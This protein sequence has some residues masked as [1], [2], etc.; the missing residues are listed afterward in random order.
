[1][2]PEALPG[3]QSEIF[4]MDTNP[5]CFAQDDFV[6][7]LSKGLKRGNIVFLLGGVFSGNPSPVSRLASK[8]LTNFVFG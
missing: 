5:A 2:F 3:S 8:L 4:Q 6:L 7:A 1:M